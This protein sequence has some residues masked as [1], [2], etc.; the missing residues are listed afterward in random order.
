MTETVFNYPGM[1]LLA[2]NA[3]T[4]TDVPLGARHR[5]R[6]HH[7]PRHRLA[8]WPTSSPPWPTPDPLC[9][10][11]KSS[12][13]AGP[14]VATGARAAAC[15]HR[16]GASCY[17]PHR[18]RAEGGEAT[19]TGSAL[20]QIGRVFVENK[21]AIVGLGV[22]VLVVLFCWLGPV[23]YKT[24]QTN[25]QAALVNSTFEHSDRVAAI[26]WAPTTPASTSSDGSCSAERTR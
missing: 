3:A 14:A 10:S 6:R 4:N 13:R 1:G 9:P 15:D 11:I 25:A 24:N 2:Y 16:S 20:R 12:D 21:L 8:G 18:G 5:P 17:G 23:F 22:I 19:S 26:L 7:G